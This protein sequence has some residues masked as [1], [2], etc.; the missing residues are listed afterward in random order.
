MSDIIQYYESFDEWG[1]LDREPVEMR[2]N[3]HFMQSFLPGPEAG[4]VLDNG[5][6]PGK[7]AMKLAAGGYRVTLTDITPKLVDKAREVAEELE[8]AR[9]FDGFHVADA[10]QLS[11]L[12]DGQFAAALMLGPMY[13]LQAE[14]DRIAAM[15]E[16]YRVTKP[17]GVVFVAFMPRTRHLVT[18]LLH[19][20]Y[21]KPNDSAEQIA[22]FMETGVFDHSE[23]GRFTGAYFTK[24]EDIEPFMRSCGFSMAKMIGSSNVAS[25]MNQGQWN[26]WQERGEADRIFELLKE[27]AENPYLLGISPH[28]MYIGTK[29]G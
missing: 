9:Q 15:K 8:L 19:P 29:V 22:A 11:C 3:W 12:E 21:W 5:A 18:S 16:L 4:A 14:E 23:A 13:H 28:I 24:V 25:L 1:R 17:G 2:V 10:M 27:T 26:Y 7:Y 20:T 6:G